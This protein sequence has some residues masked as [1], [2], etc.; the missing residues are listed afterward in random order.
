MSVLGELGAAWTKEISRASFAF[1]DPMILLASKAKSR[2]YHTYIP[3][4]QPC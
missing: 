2:I 1:V 3:L 4:D